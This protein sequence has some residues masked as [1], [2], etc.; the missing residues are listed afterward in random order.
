MSSYVQELALG[1]TQVVQIKSQAAERK[2]E[3]ASEI[4]DIKR[5]VTLMFERQ[6]T[7]AA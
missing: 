3:I 7:F 2:L 1:R 6:A 4:R 5:M